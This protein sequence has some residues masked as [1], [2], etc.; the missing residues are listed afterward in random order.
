MSDVSWQSQISF[1]KDGLNDSFSSGSQGADLNGATKVFRNVQTVATT[2]AGDLVDY[3]DIASMGLAMFQNLD[4]TNF[5]EL[6]VQVAGTFYPVLRLYFGEIVGPIRMSPTVTSSL[7][8]R[9]DTS[10][11]ELFVLLYN[12]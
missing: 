2:V 5:V 7:Y 10:A 3:G 9:A 4:D 8:A 6:G 11:V 1:T 12:D